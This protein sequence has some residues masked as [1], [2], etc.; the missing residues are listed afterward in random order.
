MFTYDKSVS[1]S[2]DFPDVA[3]GNKDLSPR[4]GKVKSSVSFLDCW[5]RGIKCRK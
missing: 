4:G 5:L 1:S 3:I 2:Q